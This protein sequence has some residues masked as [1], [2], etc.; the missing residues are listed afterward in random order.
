MLVKL[1]FRNVLRQKMRTGMT[2][3]A[4]VFGVIGILLSGGFIADVFV[5]LAEATIHSQSGHLQIFKHDFL[6]KGARYPDRYLIEKPEAL[7]SRFEKLS[8]VE[9]VMNRLFFSG[10]INNGRRDLAIIGE[11]IEA[12]KETSLGSFIQITAGRG[13]TN[14]DHQGI[15]VGQ[16]VAHTLALAPGS[17]VTLIL[18]AAGGA[19]NTQDF[20][21]VG[22]F[23]SFSKDFDARAVRIPLFAARE[24]MQTSGSNLL[25][26]S[27]AKTDQTG[28]LQEKIGQD[29]PG[30]YEIQNWKQLSD[31][32]EKTVQLYDRQFGVL[33]GIIL[34]MVLLSVA[35]SVNMSVF[36]RQGEFGTMQATG[37]TPRNIAVL[38]LTENI[39]IGAAGSVIGVT[40]GIAIA[41]I[42]S[43]IGIPMPPPPNAN[44]GYIAA[45]QIV[46]DVVASA[47]AI[48]FASTVLA[49]I[50][51][52]LK[53]SRIPVVDA[54]RQNV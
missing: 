29:L 43:A 47:A 17:R 45:I 24:L 14:N 26:F 10:L 6:S 27:L 42:T 7:T 20:E 4:I 11:G 41:W 40:L 44:V 34:I 23:Q 54:L 8:G 37:N 31:F 3:A 51:P 5:Q 30:E 21:V 38:I 50:L 2:L 53:I 25:V 28:A 52:A 46:P 9:S 36:E 1:A 35:N 39:I 19:M 15:V 16:G 13:L 49:A 48:G 12:D 33:Q 22:I 32:Y 18:S